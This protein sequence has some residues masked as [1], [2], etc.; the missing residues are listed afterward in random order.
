MGRWHR[1][2][3]HEEIKSSFWISEKATETE[4]KIIKRIVKKTKRKK[5][6]IVRVTSCWIQKKEGWRPQLLTPNP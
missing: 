2:R 4:R 5:K 3:K 1:I 6:K